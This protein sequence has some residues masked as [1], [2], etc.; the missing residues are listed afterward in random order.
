MKTTKTNFLNQMLHCDLIWDSF[1]L[2]NFNCF[3]KLPKSS[4]LVTT[5]TIMWSQENY[6]L[7]ACKKMKLDSKKYFHYNDS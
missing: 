1:F 2:S 4:F 6:L 5:L 3:Y 7:V